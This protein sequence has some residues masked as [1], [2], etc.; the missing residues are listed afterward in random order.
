MLTETIVETETGTEKRKGVTKGG[1]KIKVVKILK[2]TPDEFFDVIEN[3]LRYDIEKY[4]KK[5]EGS[6]VL[7]EGFSYY[8]K[9]KYK[10]KEYRT[11][12]E[13]KKF[14]PPRSYRVLIRN[15]I[16]N[17]AVSYDV[18]Q[19]GENE[20]E[21]LYREDTC[22]D[23]GDINTSFGRE[24]FGKIQG[25]RVKRRLAQMEKHIRNRRKQ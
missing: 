19:R 6:Y 10:K 5:A 15:D 4:G 16:G 18:S 14:E 20:I 7:E 1:E 8:K 2:V 21:V 13:V 3:S 12:T 23:S 11:L 9:I 24:L 17:F 22:D 25:G